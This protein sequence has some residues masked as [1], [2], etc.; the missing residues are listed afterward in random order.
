MLSLTTQIGFSKSPVL[1]EEVNESIWLLMKSN[2]APHGKGF[3]SLGNPASGEGGCYDLT[4]GTPCLDNVC[5]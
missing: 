1:T 2:M 3:D 4:L 5:T